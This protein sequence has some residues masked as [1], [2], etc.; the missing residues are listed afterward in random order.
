MQRS[1]VLLNRQI[2]LGLEPAD[3]G[4]LHLLVFHS[5]SVA[6]GRSPVSLEIIEGFFLLMDF[7]DSASKGFRSEDAALEDE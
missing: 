2:Q 3:P 7:P 1:G 4:L 5:S 6:L